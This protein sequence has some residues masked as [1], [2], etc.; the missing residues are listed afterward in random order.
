MAALGR[1]N[2]QGLVRARA[3][4]FLNCF[5]VPGRCREL[6]GGSYR[7]PGVVRLGNL[8]NIYGPRILAVVRERLGR[9]AYCAPLLDPCGSAWTLIE[10]LNFPW[11]ELWDST[12]RRVYKSLSMRYGL[13]PLSDS[14]LSLRLF[15]IAKQCL[16][17]ASAS[18]LNRGPCYGWTT[19]CCSLVDLQRKHSFLY[20]V[21]G[22]AS[23][24]VK[25]T[26][27]RFALAGDVQPS[28][29]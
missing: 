10:V 23:V 14:M 12:T 13:D 27:V 19:C 1:G 17:S 6:F 5:G 16:T 20:L 24:F 3:Y 22:Y 4:L 15:V 26:S 18:T 28:T 11:D 25:R 8:V 21:S 29:W 9:E 7:A 2:L